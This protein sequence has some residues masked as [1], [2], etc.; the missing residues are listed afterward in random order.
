MLDPSLPPLQT[1]QRE[2]QSWAM[3]GAEAVLAGPSL[4]QVHLGPEFYSCQIFGV[5]AMSVFWCG[6]LCLGGSLRQENSFSISPHLPRIFL[7]Q[8][9]MTWRLSEVCPCLQGPTNE[10]KFYKNRVDLKYGVFEAQQRTLLPLLPPLALE[11]LGPTWGRGGQVTRNLTVHGG[12]V[13][14]T[15]IQKQSF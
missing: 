9:V 14:P 13:P 12:I 4:T 6:W 10:L 7:R 11:L 1:E 3:A 2:M 15:S 8:D 5:K